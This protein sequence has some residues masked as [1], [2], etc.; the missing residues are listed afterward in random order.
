MLLGAPGPGVEAEVWWKLREMSLWF[1]EKVSL[2]DGAPWQ[3][4]P[5]KGTEGRLLVPA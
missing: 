2:P 3:K 1:P 5:R 4:A